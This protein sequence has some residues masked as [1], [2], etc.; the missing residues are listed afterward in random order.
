MTNNYEATLVLDTRGNE[1]SV[2]EMLR[3]IEGTFR[4]NDAEV[5]EIRKLEKR[6]LSYETQRK[7]LGEGFFTVV[8]FTADSA[9]I[10]PLRAALK[11]DDNILLTYVGK[12]KTAV[13]A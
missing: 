8:Y 4:K 7:H 11:L 13:A 9:K 10:K 5:T 6:R 1:E 12:L 2:D 3:T